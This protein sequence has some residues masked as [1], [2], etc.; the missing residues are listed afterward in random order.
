MTG[1]SSVLRRLAYHAWSFWIRSELQTS[2]ACRLFD[3]DLVVTPGVLH[4]RHFQSSTMLATELGRRPLQ[5]LDVADLGTGSGLLGLIAARGGARVIATD[6]SPAAADCARANA[7]RNRLGGQMTVLAANVLE[8]VPGPAAFDLIVTNPPFYPRPPQSVPDHAF[9][10]GEGHAFFSTL[11]SSLP[12]RL[13]PGGHLL[14]VH[15]S[16]TDFAPVSELL[17]RQGLKGRILH[18]RK[19]IFETLTIREFA[20]NP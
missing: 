19:G 20:R 18:N 5:G 12:S 9:A 1:F 17:E 7:D 4:P 11:A 13:K 10:A 16:D 2:S 8:G 6:I 3:L 14:L 15:S